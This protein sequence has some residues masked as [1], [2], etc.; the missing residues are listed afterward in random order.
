MKKKGRLDPYAYIPLNRTKL[1][2]RY[3]AVQGW[4]HAAGSC[5]LEGLILITLN[6]VAEVTSGLACF[7]FLA[8]TFMYLVP[9]GIKHDR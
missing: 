9:T 7:Y 3:S 5:A 2:R 1:N 8:C 6:S 4:G